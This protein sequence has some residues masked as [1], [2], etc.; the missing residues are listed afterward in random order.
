MEVIEGIE[1]PNHVIDLEK[2]NELIDVIKIK[3]KEHEAF[4]TLNDKEYEALYGETLRTLYHLADL[5][6]PAFEIAE[7]LE[8]QYYRMYKHAPELA[9]KLWLKK[10]HE[11][12]KPYNL[13]K[14]RCYTL[15]DNL[16]ILYEEI[17][18]CTPKLFIEDI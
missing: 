7:K 3:F 5:S 15:L 2:I 14:N 17:H 13:Y 11:T 18:K 6:T 10:Y 9:K 1:I 8:E 4:G 16:D 12:H